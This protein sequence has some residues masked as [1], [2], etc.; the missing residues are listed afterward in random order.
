MM[1]EIELKVKGMSCVHCEMQ[2]KKA[3]ES[4]DGVKNVNVDHKKGRAWITLEEGSDLDSQKL[5][6]AVNATEVYK[7]TA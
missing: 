6:E 2:V 7:A 4:V 3:L 1:N 5:V